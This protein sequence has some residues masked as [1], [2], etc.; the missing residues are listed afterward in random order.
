MEIVKFG[1]SPSL[2]YDHGSLFFGGALMPND[3]Q[4]AVVT[5]LDTGADGKVFPHLIT[6]NEF[7]GL[8]VAHQVYMVIFGY[9]NYRDIF[10]I[11]HRYQFCRE[12]L[13]GYMPTYTQALTMHGCSDYNYVDNN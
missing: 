4:P 10:G 9:M 13:F 5:L 3:P 7:N 8:V 11:A 2:K 12:Q 6:Q 1:D